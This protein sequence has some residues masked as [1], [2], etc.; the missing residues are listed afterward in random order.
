MSRLELRDVSSGESI[1]K[2]RAI[3]LMQHADGLPSLA[4]YGIV[5]FP[6]KALK[7]GEVFVK[8]RFLSVDP[9]MRGSMGFQGTELPPLNE[10]S[11]LMGDVL[12]RVSGGMNVGEV[13]DSAA[14]HLPVG[15]LVRGGWMWIDQVVLHSSWVEKLQP[16]HD[17]P[18]LA[19]G[20]VGSTARTAY[21]GVF[22]VLKPRPG[23]VLFVTAA[24]GATGMVAGQ[25]GKIAGCRV[26]GSAGSD[27]KVKYLVE[28]LGFDGAFNYRKE[29][30]EVALDRLVPGGIDLFFENTGGAVSEA[31]I[32]RLR[33][34]ARIAV[35]GIIDW[36]HDMGDMWRVLPKIVRKFL[37]MSLDSIT[38]GLA[39]PSWVLHA[40]AVKYVAHVVI[41]LN[42]MNI[43][44]CDRNA[45]Q[46]TVPTAVGSNITVENFLVTCW[47]E[48]Q[49]SVEE[50]LSGWLQS[51]ELKNLETIVKGRLEEVPQAFIKML[52]GANLGKQVVELVDA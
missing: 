4:N 14:D 49:A 8:T 2:G 43:R 40:L 24:A 34:G 38:Q 17:P 29:D 6:V 21:H 35:S 27:S 48:T 51:G 10:T 52:A 15:S 44:K 26:F 39:S 22:D 33:P 3:V 50:K 42:Q 19:L 37:P 28:E 23:E 45:L 18:S 13:V 32:S 16:Y 30:V 12:P 9:Y 11:D 5:T 25:L 41:P 7:A 1:G 47:H 36:Y 46:K 31:V 20:S